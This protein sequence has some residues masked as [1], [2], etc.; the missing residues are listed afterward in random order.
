[1]T[2]AYVR[3]ANVTE[4][5]KAMKADPDAVVLAGG[6][7]VNRAPLDRGRPAS[8]IDIRDAVAAGIVREG[9]DVVIGAMATLQDIADSEAVPPVLA[10]AAGFIPTRS[11]RNQATIGGNIAAARADSYLIPAL[12]AL[13]GTVTTAEGVLSAEEYVFDAHRELIV[14]IHVPVPVGPCVVVKESRSHVALPVVSAAVSLAPPDGS[15]GGT[16]SGACVAVGCVAPRVVR[17]T[18]VE[19]GIVNGTLSDRAAIEEAIR[20]EIAPEADILGSSAYKTYINGVVVAGAVI[21]CLEAL[22]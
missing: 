3:P 2:T 10:E 4:A 13:S 14:E 8:V 6:T 12:I 15:S 1:M 9:T 21:R 5:V 17:L 19:E 11:V 22:S 7:Q 16:P 18:G 20:K